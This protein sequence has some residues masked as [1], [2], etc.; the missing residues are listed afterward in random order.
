MPDGVSNDWGGWEYKDIFIP[1]GMMVDSVYG[2]F[3]RPGYNI[4]AH[5]YIFSFNNGTTYNSSTNSIPFSYSS[6]NTTMYNI[7]FDLTMSNYIGP[8][9][10][11]VGLPTNASATWDSLGVSTSPY[12]GGTDCYSSPSDTCNSVECDTYGV[13]PG[14]QP[15]GWAYKEIVIP[16]GFSIDSINAHFSRSNQDIYSAY[17]CPGCTVFDFS[18]STLL[19]GANI[20]N[21]YNDWVD[22]TSESL[23]GNGILRVFAP[24]Q[25]DPVVWDS[26]CVSI[27]PLTTDLSELFALSDMSIFPN[28]TSNNITISSS[29]NGVLMLY[30]IMGKEIRS[31]V[32][33]EK[34]ILLNVANLNSGVYFIQESNGN[35]VKFIKN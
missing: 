15:T 23:I 33:S 12:T 34:Q 32:K 35:T 9:M 22:L 17:Y 14:P 6:I 30:N 20:V 5:D 2:S 28:P 24:T 11:R 4:D 27:S 1:S 31:I 29:K 26:I 10:I 3:K 7:W 16:S 25:A 18:S 8:G 13:G 19:T 21:Q